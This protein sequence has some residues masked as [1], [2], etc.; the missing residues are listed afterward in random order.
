MRSKKWVWGHSLAAIEGS[1]SAGA[2]MAVFFE[3]C[4]VS[5]RRLCVGLITRPEEF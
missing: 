4:V 1:N 5:S 3:C 2:K